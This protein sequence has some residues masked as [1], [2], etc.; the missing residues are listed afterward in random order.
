[1][2]DETTPVVVAELGHKE[3][4]EIFGVSKIKNGNRYT[5]I[6][7]ARMSVVLYPIK[8]TAMVWISA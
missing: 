7:L 8:K 1:V 3:A 4:G 5:T 2:Y 6:H